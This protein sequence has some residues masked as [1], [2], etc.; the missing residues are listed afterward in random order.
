[1][2]GRKCSKRNAFENDIT[3]THTHTHTHTLTHSHTHSHYTRRVY[4]LQAVVIN[5]WRSADNH[6]TPSSLS[7]SSSSSSSSSLAPCSRALCIPGDARFSTSPALEE[8]HQDPHP[9]GPPPSDHRPRGGPT[10]G[11][12]APHKLNHTSTTHPPPSSRRRRRPPPQSS[13]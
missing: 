2:R 10:S 12:P 5:L 6:D 11:W 9:A 8:P 3:H 7:S 4:G 1:M 13:S